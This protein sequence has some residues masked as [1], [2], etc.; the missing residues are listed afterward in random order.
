MKPRFILTTLAALASSAPTALHA[1][2]PTAAARGFDCL[3]EARQ[4]IELRSPV[5]GVVE[6]ML[7]DRGALVRKG[8][9]LVELES[10][11][12]RANLQVA[13]QRAAMTGRIEAAASRVEFVR[14]KLE[15]TKP[16]LEGE[17]VAAQ[18]VDEIETELRLAEAE[19]REARAAQE[20]ARLE[21]KRAEEQLQQ[22]SMRSPLDGTVIERLLQPGELA[23]AGAGRRPMLKLAQI[24]PL[25]V[26]A[27]LPQQWLGQLRAGSQA[28]VR[29]EGSERALAAVVTLADRVIDA[30]SGTF[31]V[32]LELA[33]ARGVAAGTRCSVEFP[34]LAGRGAGAP[35]I[36]PAA[37]GGA[38]T[39][40]PAASASAPAVR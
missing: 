8:Q 5:E 26:E 2:A 13:R 33:A 35:T 40:R 37:A 18:T 16:M 31:G 29:P 30:A 11:I 6:R 12:E 27:V 19:L 34:A 23:E 9:L 32:R 14:R 1:G 15:R 36:S 38:R 24:D 3:I 39:P 28:L 22:R 21:L 25:R 7:V 17:F 4:V 10:S 20:L